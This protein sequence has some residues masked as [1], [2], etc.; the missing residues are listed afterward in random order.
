MKPALW[1]TETQ[2]VHGGQTWRSCDNFI[3]DFS[4]TTNAF[5]PPSS[6]VQAAHD[7]LLTIDHYP[8]ADN[9]AATAA[10][11]SFCKWPS[12]QL[13]I[14]NGA[15]EFIDLIMKALPPGPFK[16]GPYIAAYKEYNRAAKAADR[17]IL[18]PD[19][20]SPAAL[21]VIIHPNSPTGHCMSIESLKET[22]IKNEST[23]FVIDESF[24]PFHGPNWRDHSALQLIDH[25]PDRLIVLASWTKLW[26]CP[27]IRIGSLAAAPDWVKTIK[28]LQTPW[29]C[30]TLAQ[31]FTVAAVKDEEYLKKTWECLR[32]WK[33]STIE[34][35]EGLG[36]KVNKDSPDWVPWVFVDTGDEK[37]AE[38]AVKRA[39]Q[40][41]C[42]I[43]PC[44]S[45]G[46]PK[47]VRIAVRR[48]DHQKVL[49]GTLAQEFGI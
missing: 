27:G 19:S 48:S 4:V 38:R 6:A 17:Q 20:S 33:K 2:E 44:A 30:N 13:L 24:M 40:V 31:M 37:I 26:S 22:I 21:Q 46:L 28:K 35:I 14:G 32:I 23:F 41:G 9:G 8:P 11:A 34:N 1:D 16:P 36:W 25:F 42:P 47:Y 3:A 12:S 10:L 39:Q 45:F 49:F 43:R 15:S 5:G 29:S 7:A 18:S